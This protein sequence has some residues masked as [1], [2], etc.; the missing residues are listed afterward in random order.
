MFGVFVKIP[1]KCLYFLMKLDKFQFPLLLFF[2][3]LNPSILISYP[4]QHSLL[5]FCILKSL[6]Y[7]CEPSANLNLAWPFSSYKS[8]PCVTYVQIFISLWIAASDRSQS[9]AL[10]SNFS[11]FF[12]CSRH[13]LKNTEVNWFNFFL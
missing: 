8:E 9:C 1:S 13:V 4:D 11:H 3:F 10:V 12:L 5:S 2:F 7:L 6:F